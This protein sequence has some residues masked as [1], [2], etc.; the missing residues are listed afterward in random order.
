MKFIYVQLDKAV[1]PIDGMC[2]T[3]R[4]WIVH[5]EK[6][7][8][9]CYGKK[10]ID[11]M[12]NPIPQCSKQ[13]HILENYINTYMPNHNIVK[14]PLVFERHAYLEMLKDVKQEKHKKHEN[15]K[16]QDNDPVPEL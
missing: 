10:Q 12:E 6:G 16:N 9:F 11:R 3:N 1:K 5:P 2:Y 7:L 14:L 4:Y 15:S 8:A 13:K